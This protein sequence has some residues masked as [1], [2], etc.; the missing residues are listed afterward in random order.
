MRALS[1]NFLAGASK[2]SLPT[3]IYP[4]PRAKLSA[5]PI[6]C[7]AL[8]GGKFQP[9]PTQ[10][11]AA[12]TN[13]PLRC[14]AP[15]QIP[16]A[17][18]FALLIP[19]IVALPR[20]PTPV[21]CNWR[22]AVAASRVPGRGWNHHKSA[23]ATCLRRSPTRY[24]T[25]PPCPLFAALRRLAALLI[26]QYR[27]HMSLSKCALFLTEDSSSSDDTDLEDIYS[28]MTSR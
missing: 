3:L 12:A 6:A 28:M 14:R 11:S 20:P 25:V 13:P 10:F 22:P 4:G 19:I 27:V 21:P 26:L 7:K 2:I 23:A 1:A 18:P 15:L 24:A 9:A 5:T 8:A 17:P 16:A